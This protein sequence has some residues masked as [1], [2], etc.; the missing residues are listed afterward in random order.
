[1]LAR[2]FGFHPSISGLLLVVASLVQLRPESGTIGTDPGRRGTAASGLECRSRR[3]VEGNRPGRCHRSGQ[4]PDG[5][6]PEP[7][8]ALATGLPLARSRAATS[9]SGDPAI[10]RQRAHDF[11]DGVHCAQIRKDICRLESEVAGTYGTVHF[12]WALVGSIWRGFRAWCFWV[13]CPSWPAPVQFEGVL[14]FSSRWTNL[15]HARPGWDP[16]GAGHFA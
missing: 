11:P 5:F 2:V 6:L 9:L 16:Q 3:G 12:H 10:H 13:I 15:S 7:G 14:A 1:H 8:A 4:R